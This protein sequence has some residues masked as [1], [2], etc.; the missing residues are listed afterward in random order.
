M[1]RSFK[2]DGKSRARIAIALVLVTMLYGCAS[3]VDVSFSVTREPTTRECVQLKG[4]VSDFEGEPHSVA[5]FKPVAAS[6]GDRVE[7]TV[8]HSPI[9][10]ALYQL[11]STASLEEQEIQLRFNT[12]DGFVVG[13]RTGCLNEHL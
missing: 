12:S 7:P 4:T 5:Y 1:V 13:F 6:D 10:P 8:Q 11:L 9:T 2:L 3:M